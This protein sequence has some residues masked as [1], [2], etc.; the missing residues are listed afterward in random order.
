MN[1]YDI[2]EG[3]LKAI[4][5]YIDTMCLES[6]VTIEYLKQYKEY[7]NKLIIAIQNRT[8]RNSNGALMGLIR[9][10]SDYDELCADDVFLKLVKDADS[11]YCKECQ[12]F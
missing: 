3:K 2:L 12:S 1:K 4:N 7:I 6:N 5:E 10:I 8:I 9:G 11:Y